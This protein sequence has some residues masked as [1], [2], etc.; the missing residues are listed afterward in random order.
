[1]NTNGVQDFIVKYGDMFDI[2]QDLDISYKFYSKGLEDVLNID[3]LVKIE[4]ALYKFTP[5][6]EFIILDGDSKKL[7]DLGA[8]LK[9]GQ[10]SRLGTYLF[11]NKNEY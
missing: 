10:S 7:A 11:F 5:T 3:G 4:N 6:K 2:N 1:M 9:S 8:K